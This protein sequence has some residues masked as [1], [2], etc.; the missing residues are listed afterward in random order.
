MITTNP[1]PFS[2]LFFWGGATYHISHVL[3]YI[4]SSKFLIFHD[5]VSFF[6][7]LE[8]N[9]SWRVLLFFWAPRLRGGGGGWQREDWGRER[10]DL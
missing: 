7:L 2:D 9:I 10:G 5:D 6:P 1:D 3:V 4:S 8:V